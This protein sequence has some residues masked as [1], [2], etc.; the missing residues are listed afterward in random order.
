MT[1]VF[2]SSKFIRRDAD[3]EKI[4]QDQL[5][6]AHEKVAVAIGRQLLKRG[7]INFE[8]GEAPGTNAGEKKITIT[9]K[10]SVAN[11]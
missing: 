3:P 9:G 5:Q 1:G 4:R 8:I 11:Q 2:N 10:I 7:L 6:E